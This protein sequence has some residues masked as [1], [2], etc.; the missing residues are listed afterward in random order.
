MFDRG[1]TSSKNITILIHFRMMSN[2]LM[3]KFNMKGQKGK[4]PFSKSALCAIVKD[5]EI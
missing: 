1:R 3:A 5:I 2:D 4:E